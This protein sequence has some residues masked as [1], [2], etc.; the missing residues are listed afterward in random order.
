M[1]Y[2][3]RKTAG[4]KQYYYLR[5]SERKKTKVIAKDIA[6]LGNSIAEVKKSL[7]ALPKYKDKIRKAYKTIHKFIES[8]HYL[9]KAIALKLKKDVFLRE[10]LEDA[11]ACRLHYAEVF[12]KS[13]AL[14]KRETMKNWIVEFA[15]NT[16]FIEGNTITLNEARNLLVDG[17]TP[18]NKTLREIYDVQNTERVFFEVMNAK[19]EISHEFI[20]KI[21]SALMQ[22]IDA[23]VG[24]R[25][26][27]MRV[28]KS[29]FDA[30]PAQYVKT[31]MKLLI[32]WYDKNK[33]IL[34]PLVLGTIFHHKFEKIHPFMDG[35]GRTGRMLMN[36]I[37]MKSNCPPVIIQ[38]KFRTQ[39]LEALRIADK[40]DLAKADKADYRTLAQ[41]TADELTSS[42]WNL[43]L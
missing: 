35:N 38:K 8:N 26:A 4:G 13:D 17:L 10:K 42:Y 18:K 28:L 19:E 14:T 29:N 3:Y 2:I 40:S 24:Y 6:Y 16:T 43:F 11:E 23:R 37:L 31:D 39:Y 30:T 33:K 7:E 12:S 22:N 9:E 20:I 25:T 15:F 5:V 21:H 32:E 27:D 34:H 1:V 36:H 41:F